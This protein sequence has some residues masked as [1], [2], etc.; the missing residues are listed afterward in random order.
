MKGKRMKGKGCTKAKEKDS[1]ARECS[2][3]KV[4]QRVFPVWRP[5][6]PEQRMPEKEVKVECQRWLE[7]RINRDW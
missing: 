3:A 1:K 5:Q 6:S 7:K 2:K 4:D